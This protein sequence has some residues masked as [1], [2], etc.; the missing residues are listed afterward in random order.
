MGLHKLFHLPKEPYLFLYND[1]FDKLK[2]MFKMI[3]SKKN[4]QAFSL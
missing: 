2:V 4:L 3:V 1:N